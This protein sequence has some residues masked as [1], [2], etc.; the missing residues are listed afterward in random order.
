[1]S[2]VSFTSSRFGDVEV[3]ADAVI[4]FPRGLIGLG[5]TQFALLGTTEEEAI[6][7]LHAVDDPDLALPVADPWAFF[8]DY[9]VELSEADTE[10][11]GSEDPEAVQ[12]LVTVRATP[13]LRD[14][15]ANLRAPILIHEGRGHQL[16]NEAPDAPMRAPLG[17][18][19]D[20]GTAS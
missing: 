19:R 11:V 12:V 18:E 20:A 7:W 17:V 13:Q 3:A 8:P 15:T 10:R 6:V 4:E 1:M 16:I 5:G 14:F 9:A 2:A